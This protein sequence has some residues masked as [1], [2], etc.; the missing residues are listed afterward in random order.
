MTKPNKFGGLWICERGFLWY[1]S[2]KRRI[3]LLIDDVS[4]EEAEKI[5]KKYRM[6]RPAKR[7]LKQPKQK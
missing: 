6:G 3:N 4:Q 7:W 5:I 2:K 1:I